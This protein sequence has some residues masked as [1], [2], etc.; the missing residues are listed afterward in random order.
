MWRTRNYI[1][2]GADPDNRD[3]YFGWLQ[4]RRILAPT[5]CP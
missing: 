3:E 2:Y 4:A 1:T 5:H